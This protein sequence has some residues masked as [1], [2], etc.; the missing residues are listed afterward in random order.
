MEGDK[1]LQSYP[2]PDGKRCIELRQQPDGLFYFQEFSEAADN[3][4]VYG[5]QT[6]TSP[7]WKSGL[8]KSAAAAEADIQKMTPWLSER[9]T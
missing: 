4:P 8:Y 7:G 9:S 3:V 1:L 2:S 6:L 5:A